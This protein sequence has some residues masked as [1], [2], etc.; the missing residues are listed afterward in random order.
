MIAS[1]QMGKSMINLVVKAKQIGIP[2]E[3]INRMIKEYYGWD[4][5]CQ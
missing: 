1:R 5:D 4:I 3:I 2:P